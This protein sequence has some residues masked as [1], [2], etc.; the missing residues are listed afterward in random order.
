MISYICVT[1]IYIPSIWN[2]E[3]PPKVQLLLWLM[4]YNKLMI[5][6]N[7]KTGGIEKPPCCQF[8]EEPKTIQQ[9]FFNCAIAKVMWDHYTC[10]FLEFKVANDHF[11]LP[12]IVNG[13]VGKSL[14][15]P[16]KWTSWKKFGQANIIL[17]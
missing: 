7:Q 4:A 14:V 16:S 5:L 11:I 10:R 3:V 12:L 9:I 8:C 13:P 2:I 1:T 15:R 6:D 17:V